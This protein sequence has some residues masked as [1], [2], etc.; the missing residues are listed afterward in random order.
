MLQIYSKGVAHELRRIVSY[1]K[2]E[3]GKELEFMSSFPWDTE[4]L[5]DGLIFLGQKDWLS[6]AYIT[7]VVPFSTQKI[8][9]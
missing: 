9:S 3:A 2:P 1:P 4:K 6:F 7:F 8:I 5:T